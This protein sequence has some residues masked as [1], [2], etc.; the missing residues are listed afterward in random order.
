MPKAILIPGQIMADNVD[1]LVKSAVCASEVENGMVGLLSATPSADEV[2]TLT[3]NSAIADVQAYMV[4]EPVLPVV[5]GKYKGITDDPTVF[6]VA[7]GKVFTVYRPAVGDEIILSTDAVTGTKSTNT[8][9]IMNAGAFKLVW[10]ATASTS[11]LV[12]KL[13]ETTSINVPGATFYAAKTVAYKLR[14]V[15]A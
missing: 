12:Y 9:A 3:A 4:N 8:F 15:L 13:I 14:C 6:S 1:S 11:S 7:A 2:F 10:S 5:D